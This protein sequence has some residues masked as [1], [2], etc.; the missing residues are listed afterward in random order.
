MLRRVVPTG[1]A[2][3]DGAR[4]GAA[5]LDV[6]LPGRH[7][8]MSKPLDPLGTAELAEADRQRQLRWA[9][10]R[11][12]LAPPPLPPRF[13]EGT[14]VLDEG[15]ELHFA[16][17]LFADASLA[18]EG[19]DHPA[20]AELKA[21]FADVLGGP[22]P[23]LPPDRGI[24]LVLETG[25]RPMQRTRPLKRLSEGELAELLRQLRDL[26]DRCWIQHSTAGHAASVVFARKPDGSWRICCDYRGLTAV[27]EPQVGPLPH[28]DALLDGTRGAKW[29]TKFDLAQGNHQVLLREADWWKTSFR[30]QL[31]QFEWKVMPFVLQG[32]SMRVLPAHDR[33]RLVGGCHLRPGGDRLGPGGQGRT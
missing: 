17:L 24:E 20:F 7:G 13:G 6:P 26:L 23:G 1:P 4:A 25:N 22:P 31:G 21:E 19:Q 5:R 18:L 9:R 14:E 33:C 3:P 28:I 29:F 12:G 27:T 10:R 8:G 11:A 2:P 16:S 15:T 32:S 30:S